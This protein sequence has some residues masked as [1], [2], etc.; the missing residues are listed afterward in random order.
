M[1]VISHFGSSLWKH[2]KHCLVLWKLRTV[3]WNCK[4][5]IAIVKSVFRRVRK[6]YRV[7]HCRNS[8]FTVIGRVTQSMKKKI[9]P[10]VF[11]KTTSLSSR[12]CWEF[13][14]FK[15]FVMEI[16]WFYNLRVA[17]CELRVVSCDFKE[18]NLRVAS[19]FLGVED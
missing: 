5:L 11:T 6:S 1:Q 8:P 10:F 3:Q 9:N 7:A 19:S 17:I 13:N 14:K 18:I 15:R 12:E 4:K 16:R 2:Q